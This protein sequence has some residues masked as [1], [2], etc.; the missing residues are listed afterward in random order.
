[1]ASFSVPELGLAILGWVAAYRARRWYA[2]FALLAIAFAGVLFV[3]YANL[4][5]A[6]PGARFVLERFFLLSHLLAAPLVAFGVVLLAELLTR[7]L[8]VRLA[9][10]ALAAILVVFVVWVA[11]RTYA[12]VDQSGNVVAR[13]FAEDVLAS[14]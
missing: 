14:L 9:R 12:V 3:L 13:H 7:R 2:W 8:D 10:G 4:N 6:I 5:L 1:V 11:T